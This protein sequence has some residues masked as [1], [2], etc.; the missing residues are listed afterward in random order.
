MLSSN[1]NSYI[2]VV[3]F[4]ESWRW[5]GYG[6]LVVYKE[7]EILKVVYFKKG[8]VVIFFV[9]LEYVFKFLVIDL[10]ECLYLMKI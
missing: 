3:F 2:V 6:E 7:G 5:N 10:L 8:R 1:V 4:V 9:F